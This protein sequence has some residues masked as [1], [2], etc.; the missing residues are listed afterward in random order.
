MV[1]TMEISTLNSHGL[2]WIHLQIPWYC[3]LCTCVSLLACYSQLQFA[4]AKD[5]EKY[6]NGAV[7]EEA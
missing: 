5:K 3:W 6:Y 4:K 7:Q 1:V 2:I